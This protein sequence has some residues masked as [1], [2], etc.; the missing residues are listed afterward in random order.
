[1]S[2]WKRWLSGEE[3]KSYQC[4]GLLPPPGAEVVEQWAKWL[5]IEREKL[6]KARGLL[7]NLKFSEELH[8]EELKELDKILGYTKG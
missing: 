3:L 8:E 5:C 1:M 6:A 7:Y 2:D 4:R